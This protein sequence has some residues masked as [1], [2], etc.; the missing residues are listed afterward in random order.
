[1][2]SFLQKEKILVLEKDCFF[3]LQKFHCIQNLGSLLLHSKKQ[4]ESSLK[5]LYLEKLIS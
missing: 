1:M 5:V 2:I 3:E 4:F